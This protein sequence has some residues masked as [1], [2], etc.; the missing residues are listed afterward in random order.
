MK[1]RGQA[2]P[3][4]TVRFGKILKKSGKY[5]VTHGGGAPG[6][7]VTEIEAQPAGGRH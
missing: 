1:W 7:G 2:K 5:S 4:R 3:G 6:T